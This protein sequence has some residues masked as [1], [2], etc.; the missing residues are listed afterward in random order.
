MWQCEARDDSQRQV[1]LVVV[2]AQ[3]NFIH[4]IHSGMSPNTTRSER[5]ELIRLIWWWVQTA[6][7]L[8][9]LHRVLPHPADILPYP[10]VNGDART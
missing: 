1:D 5:Q 7:A 9:N 3:H 4:Y 6:S 2:L 8:S 10:E